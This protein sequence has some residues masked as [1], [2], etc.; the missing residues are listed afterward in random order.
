MAVAQG[1][2]NLI[3]NQVPCQFQRD[4]KPGALSVFNESSH[5]PT[6]SRGRS[7]KS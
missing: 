2:S 6:N 5:L 4:R 3:H 7:G 1:L